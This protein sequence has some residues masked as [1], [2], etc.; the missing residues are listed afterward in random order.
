MNFINRERSYPKTGHEIQ[1]FTGTS[2]WNIG[3]L[4][5]TRMKSEAKI[6]S[7]M[8]YIRKNNEGQK[9]AHWQEQLKCDPVP[10]LLGSDN[11]A[12][13]YFTQRDLL[14]EE[15]EPISRIWELPK[16]QRI[17]KKQQSNGSW[18]SKNRNR[19]RY[20]DVNYDLIETWRQLRYLIEQYEFTR[21]HPNLEKA[22]EFI[23]SCQTEDGDIRG[24]LANQ[25]AM[26]YTGAIMSSLIKAGY[27]ED[28]RIEKGF[29]WLLSMR[30]DDMGW[31]ATPGITIDR[32]WGE[33]C[34]ISSHYYETIEEIDRSIPSSHN[35]TG[36]V[37]RAFAAHRKY[38]KSDAAISAAAL[39]KSRF[40]KQEPDPHTSYKHADNWLRFQY[41]FWWNDLV[42]AL[43]SVSLIG[44]STDDRDISAALCWLLAH[45]E[46]NGLWRTSYSRIHKSPPDNDKTKEMGLWIGLAICRILK[47][48]SI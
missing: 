37:I 13:K 26:Y 14:E 32:S 46:E 21:I 35:A 17:L 6:S 5:R 27:E 10:P 36:M 30:Q 12:I 11:I 15:V 22:A 28:P 40:F 31:V 1:A 4:D 42:A 2:K 8:K 25:Y 38:R 18:R 16:V 20:P 39:L 7:S 33:K 29:K 34:D 47:R 44:L 45:Q 19:E 41:P 43:D 48:Y 24:M 23:F 3:L 9:M